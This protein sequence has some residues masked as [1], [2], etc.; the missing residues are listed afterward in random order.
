MVL[1]GA[2][3][4]AA[5]V[6]IPLATVNR[7]GL[8]AGATGTGKTKTLQ[9]IAEQ[10]SAAGVPVVMADVKGDLSGLS[11]P[12][13]AGDK[14]TARAAETGDDEWAPAGSPVEFLSLGTAGH[15]HS[16]PRDHHRVRADPAQQG[17]RAQ[18]DS[19]VDAGADLPLGRRPGPRAAR[20]EGSAIGHRA[21]HQRRGQGRSEGHR[22]RVPGH[23]R[24]DPA[25][26]GQPR[27][28][29]RRHVLR[30]ARA[31]DRGPAPGVGR[32][33]RDH[34]VRVGRRRPRARH[35]SPPS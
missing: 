34:V 20:P 3:D 29:R 5:R 30:G 22:R 1:D 28:R 21:S 14:I 8:V 11:Q 16:R 9:G 12:G 10:L 27:S 18:R 24:R 7:H 6:R 2:V 35:C 31:R 25:G 15:R 26:P 17:A 32:Q 23:G 19:G 33:G 13:E 4:P